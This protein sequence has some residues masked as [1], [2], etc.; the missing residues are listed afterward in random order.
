MNGFYLPG[1]IDLIIA[2]RDSAFRAK[3][4]AK[5]D[6]DI[7][8]SDPVE[9]FNKSTFGKAYSVLTDALKA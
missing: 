6:G 1:W 2:V 4:K 5:V 7:L 9:D 8:E 3:E